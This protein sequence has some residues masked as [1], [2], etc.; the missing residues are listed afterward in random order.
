[1]KV[2]KEN[3][4]IPSYIIYIIILVLVIGVCILIIVIYFKIKNLLCKKIKHIPSKV[5]EDIV[6]G[7]TN[8]EDFGKSLPRVK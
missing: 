7:D 4:N 3:L 1:M 2:L 8:P 6:L 5:Y